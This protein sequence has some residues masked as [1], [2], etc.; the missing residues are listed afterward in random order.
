[1]PNDRQGPIAIGH[2][3]DWTKKWLWLSEGVGSGDVGEDGEW[4]EVGVCW[5]MYIYHNKL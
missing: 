2:L 5:Y 4:G 3:S 1:M